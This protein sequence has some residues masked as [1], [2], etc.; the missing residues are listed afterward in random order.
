MNEYKTEPIDIYDSIKTFSF[1][2]FGKE[3][4]NRV[5]D[6]YISGK[7]YGDISKMS[8]NAVL[9]DLMEYERSFGSVIKGYMKNKQNQNEAYSDNIMSIKDDSVVSFKGGLQYLVDKIIEHHQLKIIFNQQVKM[10]RQSNDKMV[11]MV[12]NDSEYKFDKVV[13]TTPSYVS[14]HLLRNCDEEYYRAF[15]LIK[16]APLAVVNLAFEEESVKHDAYGYHVPVSENQRMISCIFN[17]KIF[18]DHSP[19][20][21]ANLAVILGGPQDFKIMEKPAH[22]IIKTALKQIENHLGIVDEPIVVRIR[23]YSRAIPQYNMG[24][25]KVWERMDAVTEKYKNIIMASNFRHG[26]QLK[27]CVKLSKK[28]AESLKE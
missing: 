22:M 5:T 25:E 24:V 13:M 8:T 21:R 16:Y 1:R 2:H 28:I 20:S 10:V 7:Y 17:H 12:V 23:Q 11:E 4:T 9:N 19:G 14:A 27:D 6:P 15:G 26:I 18:P 3:F